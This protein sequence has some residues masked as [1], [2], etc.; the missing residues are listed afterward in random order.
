MSVR[1]K[2]KVWAVATIGTAL[3]LGLFGCM[4]ESEKSAGEEGALIQEMPAESLKFTK[5]EGETKK[6][7]G[8]IEGVPMLFQDPELPT[9]CE[10]TAL[11]MVLQYYGFDADKCELSDVYLPK[12]AVGETDFHY[13]FV[14]EPREQHSYGC[15]APAIVET[16]LGYLGDMDGLQDYT[17]KDLTGM[18][19]KK[20]FRYVE[21]GIPVMVWG[22]MKNKESY[23][24]TTWEVNGKT[25]T[26]RAGEHCRVLVGYNKKL[27]IVQV[28]DPQEGV[29]TYDVSVFEE[30]YNEMGKQAVVILP[31]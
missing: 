26:W 11:A 4:S 25:I 13:A 8:K 10:V 31:E 29:L 28:N 21:E 23:L 22:T 5:F 20:L 14:G 24:T 3:L 7:S 16:A 18:E 2:K 17:V 27:G 30:R 19:L 15:Y 6:S 12:G 9:G 1:E